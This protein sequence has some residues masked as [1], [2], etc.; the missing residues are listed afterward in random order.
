MWVKYTNPLVIFP[1]QLVT[2]LGLVFEITSQIV[3]SPYP[4]GEYS[5]YE[6]TNRAS[7]SVCIC[8]AQTGFST[9]VKV[10]LALHVLRLLYISLV[11]HHSA[12]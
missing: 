12:C 5:I 2:D 6:F 3:Y 8:K 4:Y 1:Y 11:R 9:F 7:Q 10:N